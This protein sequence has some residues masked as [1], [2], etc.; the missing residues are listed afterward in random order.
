[1]SFRQRLTHLLGNSNYRIRLAYFVLIG[2]VLFLLA[3]LTQP[4][5]NNFL[6]QVAFV[7]LGVG[8]IEVLWDFLGGDPLEEKIGSEFQHIDEK[9]QTIE[10]SVT[11]LSDIVDYDLGIKHIWPN[12]DTWRDDRENGFRK[13]HEILCLAQNV[14]V[15]SNTFHRNWM[16]QE[17]FTQGLFSSL[18]NTPKKMQILLYHPYSTNLL[19]RANQENPENYQSLNEMRNEIIQSLQKTIVELIKPLP[20]RARNKIEIR[21][22]VFY[23]HL[24]QIIIADNKMLV[25]NYLSDESG[26]PIPTMQIEG[27]HTKYFLT[28]KKQFDTLWKYA[29]KLSDLISLED[30]ENCQEAEL[31][32]WLD[33]NLRTLEND[34]IR[35]LV[36]ESGDLK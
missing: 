22:T 26:H 13:W 7:F 29:A 23:Y 18:K 17:Q 27:E 10:N 8:L 15:V 19:I 16:E 1:M 28:Y 20:H 11:G 5:L 12:R 4:P 14:Q 35:K 3:W 9:L 2:F 21:L 31:T 36:V 33:R 30:A 25:S 6:E 24:A 34:P 32:A